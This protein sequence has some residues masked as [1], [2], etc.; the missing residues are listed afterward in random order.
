MCSI[1]RCDTLVVYSLF[2][3]APSACSIKNLILVLLY[4]VLCGLSLCGLSLS[5]LSVCVLC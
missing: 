4:K 5:V 1:I 3:V 2:G